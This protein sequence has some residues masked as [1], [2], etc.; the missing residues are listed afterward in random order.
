MAH[1]SGIKDVAQRAGV[2]VGTVSNVFNRPDLVAPTTRQRVEQAAI[3]LR[4][5]RNESARQLRVGQ[6]RTI[7][8]VVPDIANPFFTDLARGID[9]VTSAAGALVIMCNS[10][11]AEKE[12]RYLTLLA[13]QQVIGVLV[14]PVSSSTAAIDRLR[15][16]DVPVVLLDYRGRT[17][18]QCSV[19][20]NDVAGGEMATSHHLEAGHRRIGFVGAP[21]DAHQVVDRLAGA[22][23]AMRRAGRDQDDLVLVPTPAL[24]VEGGTVAARTVLAMPESERPTALVCVNDLLAL[25]VLRVLLQSGTAVPGDIAITGYDDIAYAA[26]AAVPLTSVRQPRGQLGRR[27]AEL[28]IEEATNPAHVH[29]RVVF[30]PELVV[31][32][33]SR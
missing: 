17:H 28:L 18:R 6:G 29:S 2:S 9:E 27:A 15:D 25:G 3:D 12:D 23:E 11:H 22:R 7:G 30:E 26:D 8:L 24:T 14:V 31:R 1:R 16:L 32:Q 4:Y 5:L 13:E 10:E 21:S 33:S 20:V 19:A